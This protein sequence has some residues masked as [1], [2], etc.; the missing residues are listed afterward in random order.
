LLGR[1]HDDHDLQPFL[2][3]LPYRTSMAPD[4]TIMIEMWGRDY[5]IVT[6]CSHLLAEARNLAEAV[7]GGSV[8]QAVVSVPITFDDG[9]VAA[10][11]RAGELADLDIVAVIDEPSAAALAN[12]YDRD[13]GGRV[14]I[15]DFGGGTFDFSIIDVSGGD[16]RVLATVG[17]TWLG[18][19]DFD[20]M[21]AEAAA[22]QFWQERKIDLRK[23]PIEWQRLL[24]ACE[25]AKRDLSSTESSI[26]SV[27]GILRTAD[28]MVDLNLA[29]TR[30]LFE[31]AC[32]PLVQRTLD[33][34]NE[35]LRL[36][37][38]AA[39]DLSAVYI[40]GGSTYVPAIRRGLHSHFAVPI[41][42]GVP[43]EYAVCLGA[44][45]HAAQMTFGAQPTIGTR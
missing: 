9:Q 13:F 26:V 39:G 30:A 25:R 27:P 18:G 40:S 41:R 11:R 42:A 14:G 8:L 31:R 7:I 21:L 12:R 36:T 35:G 28:G 19:D 37:G 17:D 10:L 44:A 22:N 2:A 45:I 38:L 6:L 23:Q 4:G 5:G 32:A 1:Q 43:P 16:F 3:Q 24:F 34:C 29:A 33:V 15:Y 20:R